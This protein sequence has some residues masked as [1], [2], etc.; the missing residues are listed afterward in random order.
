MCRDTITVPRVLRQVIA[1]AGQTEPDACA[2]RLS[3]DA[4][5]I[6]AAQTVASKRST[7]FRT[8]IRTK[9]RSLAEAGQFQHTG[10][11]ANAVAVE[12]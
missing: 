2:T 1:F 6:L 5:L 3:L 9:A 10:A 7:A 11:W 8:L 4:K 12:A